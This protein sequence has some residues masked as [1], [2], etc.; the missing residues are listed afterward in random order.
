VVIEQAKGILAERL[1]VDP[2]QAFARLRRYGRLRG[3]RLT[4]LARR[5]V[6]GSLTIDE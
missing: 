3:L 6:D 4:D 5:V 2:D 1:G